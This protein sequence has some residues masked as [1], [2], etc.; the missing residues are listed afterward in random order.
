MDLIKTTGLMKTITDIGLF[1]EKLVK[2]FIVY[3]SPDCNIEGSQ[4]YMKVYVRGKCVKFS[5]SII[6]DYLGRSKSVK[7]NKTSSIDKIAKE[8]TGEQVKQ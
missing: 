6:N 7:S 3:I 5:P 4:K 1:Y 8:I 2:K